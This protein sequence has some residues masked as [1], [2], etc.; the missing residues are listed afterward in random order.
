MRE[1]TQAKQRPVKLTEAEVKEAAEGKS[2]KVLE[3]RV[4]PMQLTEAEVKEAAEGR[5]EKVWERK[6]KQR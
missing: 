6:M 4:K 1:E 2:E 5:S 3:R